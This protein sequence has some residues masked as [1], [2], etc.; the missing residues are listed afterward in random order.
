MSQLDRDLEALKDEVITKKDI[1]AALDLLSEVLGAA[2]VGYLGFILLTS[3]LPGIGIPISG[4]A[5]AYGLRKL[6]E[7]YS[8][9]P[10]DQRRAVAL[11]VRK[12]HTLGLY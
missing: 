10:T 4:G 5:A 6:L 8:E 11:V 9:L 1:K 7:G 12:L 2:A 3:W